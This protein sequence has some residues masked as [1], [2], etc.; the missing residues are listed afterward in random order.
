MIIKMEDL[1]SKDGT[2]KAGKISIEIKDLLISNDEVILDFLG[3]NTIFESVFEEIFKDVL[4]DEKA[5]D[6]IK[7]INARY[8]V[9]RSLKNIIN[10]KIRISIE[11]G[12]NYEKIVNF[13]RVANH[14]R[15]GL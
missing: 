6:K 1:F 15:N 4:G 5:L 3:I 2:A 13:I 9:Q 11:K 8:S 14:H 10:K 7:V 12:V